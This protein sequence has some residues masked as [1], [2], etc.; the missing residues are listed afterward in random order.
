MTQ[1]IK[2]P[3]YASV[4]LDRV[5]Y[6]NGEIV[7]DNTS[8]T[9][10]LMDG[11]T[12]GGTKLAT[13]A[14]VADNVIGGA[15]TADNPPNNPKDGQLWFNTTNGGMYV[16]YTDADSSQW[17]E[18]SVS[19]SEGDTLNFP[20][21]PELNQPYTN[22][23]TT[24]LWDGA[25]WRVKA[26]QNPT[27]ESIE[28]S[29]TIT[30]NALVITNEAN[31]FI[32]NAGLEVALMPYATSVGVASDIAA[33]A[34]T[35]PTATTEQLGG[36]KVDGATITIN[37][38]VITGAQL[39]T[40]PTAT[41][42]V[43]GGITVPAVAT[44]GLINT[45]GAITL[46]TASNTQL[47][48]VKVDGATITINNGVISGYAG[49]T[50]PT[51][52]TS[53]K[54]GITIAATSTS[55]LINTSGSVRLATATTTQLGGVKVDGTTITINS[56]IISANITGAITYQGNWSASANSPAL[57]DGTGA[58]GW[59]YSVT[60][61][62]TVTFGVGNTVTFAVGDLAIYANGLWTKIPLGSASGTTNSPITFNNTG[63][64]SNSGA[65]FNGSASQTISYNTIGAEPAGGS[66]EIATLGVVTIGTWNS[67]IIDPTY[68]G[69][70]VN[71]GAS[72]LTLTNSYT[73]NQSVANG[74]S[75]T[76]TG[77]N[78]TSIPNSALTNNSITINGAAISL[79]G[80][81]TTPQGTV[82]SIATS[83][84]VSGITLTGGTITSSGTITL[85]GTLSLV[86]PGAIGGTT[87]NTVST[88]RLIY[89]GAGTGGAATQTVARTNAVSLNTITG[90]ITLLAGILNA[91]TT[92]S[93]TLNNTTI[94]ATDHVIV[95]HSS[96][97][98]AGIYTVT[99]FPGSNLAT[100]YVRNV[101]A[102]NSASESPV[103]KFTVIKSVNA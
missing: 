36:V 21:S 81:V 46:A 28:V 73:L 23:T 29:G 94:A 80:T 79:G 3:T 55:G 19:S 7:A 78:F 52:T 4:D 93:F 69:T 65:T 8:G 47:G 74:A 101:T 43:K 70:G 92:V 26:E 84:N 45:A 11:N 9:I 1:R 37:N 53:V 32:T 99:A 15:T 27:Y 77:T 58:Q 33:A 20:P 86:S 67:D 34:Y 41:T 31:A 83:G 72:T 66:V 39:Y 85:G 76:F 5:S 96:G 64:G 14:W 59:E 35:L 24:W 103:L 30:T 100:I 57:S 18:V 61:A 60:T 89:A 75:P 97:G 63:L 2:L 12:P 6:S 88:T 40:L 91:N 17:A 68:G 42:S 44:S 56:G 98:T 95:T 25:Q 54:G 71:N 22:G 82:T 50:L 51:A 48:G 49:Y 90:T 38:G 10:R 102:A 62:G 13:R 16:Y 87:P